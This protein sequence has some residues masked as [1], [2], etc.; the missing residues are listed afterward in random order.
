MVPVLGKYRIT[1]EYGLTDYARSTAGKKAYKN[2]PGGIHPGYD[3]GTYGVNSEIVSMFDG[4]VVLAKL[5][6]GWGNHIMITAPDGWNRNYAHCESILVKVGDQVKKGQVIGRVGTTGASTGVHLHYGKRKWG[7]VS[8]QYADP[9]ADFEAAPVVATMPASGFVQGGDAK[10]YLWDGKHL[11][12]IPN[13]QTMALFVFSKVTKVPMELFS[14]MPI[15][16]PIP[17]LI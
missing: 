11:H 12:Y 6:G 3:F 5:D 8:W 1:Q 10:I 14:K 17:S 13:P 15:G 7:I 2:F 9:S 16:D 4:K